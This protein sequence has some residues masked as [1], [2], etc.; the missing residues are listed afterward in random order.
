MYLLK[1]INN[2]TPTPPRLPPMAGYMGLGNLTLMLKTQRGCLPHDE[3]CL[4]DNVIVL[5]K[6]RVQKYQQTTM[7][8]KEESRKMK[9]KHLALNLA[10]QLTY[11]VTDEL[12]PV[13]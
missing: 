8:K 11:L 12:S 3:D 5:V 13:F 1:K 9:K 7:A 2:I 6:K 10:A 4:K